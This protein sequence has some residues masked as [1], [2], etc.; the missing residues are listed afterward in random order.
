MPQS[1]KPE[2]LLQMAVKVLVE[3]VMTRLVTVDVPK[4]SKNRLASV[5]SGTENPDW[6]SNGITASS[7]TALTGA[8]TAG[9]LTLEY[10]SQNKIDSSY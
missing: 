9:S 2:V 8:S 5:P 10:R 7:D 6:T 4:A 1:E 3:V